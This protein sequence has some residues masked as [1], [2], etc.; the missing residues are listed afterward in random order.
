MPQWFQ[1][2]SLRH[3]C[4][5]VVTAALMITALSAAASCRSTT[6]PSAIVNRPRQT[7]W[8]ELA[9][10]DMAALDSTKV[11]EVAGP[12]SA[13]LFRTDIGIMFEPTVT[14]S[15][16]NAL[17]LREGITVLGYSATRNLFYAR[18][19]DPGPLVDSLYA[20]LERLDS[21][22]EI[23][24]AISIPATPPR[25]GNRGRYPSDGVLDTRSRWLDGTSSWAMNAIRAP[26]LLV[27]A[28]GKR[29]PTF[30]GGMYSAAPVAIGEHPR[31][32]WQA[33]R[34]RFATSGQH[35]LRG[36]GKRFVP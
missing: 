35:A 32:G 19:P 12:G 36:T 11:V 34:A 25:P 28:S 24:F 18:I 30:R 15:A 7:F 29:K 20:A 22:P 8:T 14:D 1:P 13:K 16:K 2:A 26:Q 5:V 31:S 9:G 4:R 6:D 10:N 33:A 23:R 17:F 3:A 27:A 21:L